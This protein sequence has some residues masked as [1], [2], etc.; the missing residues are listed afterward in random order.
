VETGRF[1]GRSPRD[2]HVVRRP[3]TE[4]Q[5]WW[6]ANAA[7]DPSAFDRL[8]EDMIAHAR[9]AGVHVQTLFAG[10]EPGT[11]IAVR[12]AT[13]RAWHALF[14][15]H[16]LRRPAPGEALQALPDWTI[17]NL[18][19]FQAV[20]ARHGGRSSTLIALDWETRWL[21]IAGTDYAGENKKAVFTVMNWLLPERGVLPMHCSANHAPGDPSD[22]AIFFGL[23]GTGKTT[24][25]SDPARPCW[26]TTSTAGPTRASSTSKGAA[27]PRRCTCAPRTSP[28]STPRP[29]C[30][31]RSSRT[32]APTPRPARSTSRT[33]RARPTPAAPT[34]SR[35]SPTPRPRAS[36]AT[37]ATS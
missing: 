31:A 14:L 28:R 7:L 8:R 6:G 36:P 19:S 2:K 15:R 32:W 33:R 10:A 34:R 13:E 27:T 29:G 4:A 23:S 17:L 16:L 11:R 9:L 18:P 20:P 30:S 21:L 37:P 26:A 22:A 25:S 35:R 24:L 3:A 1:T 12:A 5:V